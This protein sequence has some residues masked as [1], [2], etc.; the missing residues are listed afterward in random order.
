MQSRTLVSSTLVFSALTAALAFTAA[1]RPVAVERVDFGKTITA[2]QPAYD[3]RVAPATDA[4]IRELVIPITHDT[5]E[6]AKG[7]KARRPDESNRLTSR[8]RIMTTHGFPAT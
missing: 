5:I 1:R 3:A 4:T 8:I 2:T 7:V 6:N